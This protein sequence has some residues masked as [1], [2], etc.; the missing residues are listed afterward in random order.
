MSDKSYK[1]VVR[2]PTSMRSKIVEAAA[3]YHRSMNSEIVARLEQ[4]FG[5]LPKQSTEEQVAPPLHPHIE[6]IFRSTLNET[7][8]KLIR[9]FRRLESTQQN[10]LLD[11][12]K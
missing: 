2:L 7:E 4:S 5:S 12:L 8:Q 3:Y 1:F 9:I 10:A 11:L 6:A